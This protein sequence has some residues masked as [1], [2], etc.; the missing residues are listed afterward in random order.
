[1]NHH[2]ATLA[3]LVAFAAAPALA[4]EEPTVQPA[5]TEAQSQAAT[6]EMCKAVMG[7]KM[8][9]KAVHDHGRDKTGAATWPNG[10]PLTAAEMEAMHKQCAD[11]MEEKAAGED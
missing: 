10:K 11:K 1:M 2:L 5:L 6:H 8:D 4:R 3:A 7:P 9:G